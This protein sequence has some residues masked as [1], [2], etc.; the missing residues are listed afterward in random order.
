MPAVSMG[1]AEITYVFMGVVETPTDFTSFSGTPRLGQMK[2]I[3]LMTMSEKID[4]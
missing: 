4:P 1:V 2:Y 3:S